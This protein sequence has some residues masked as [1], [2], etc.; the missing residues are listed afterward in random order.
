MSL[1]RTL[2][3]FVIAGKDW[4][5]NVQY[6]SGASG[7]FVKDICHAKLYKTVSSAQRAYPFTQRKMLGKSGDDLNIIPVELRY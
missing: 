2:D 7:R 4:Q 1:S 5:E 3:A 6:Y